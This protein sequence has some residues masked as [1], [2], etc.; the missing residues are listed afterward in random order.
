MLLP[1]RVCNKGAKRWA[2]LIAGMVQR[3]CELNRPAYQPARFL[4]WAGLML[5]SPLR[6]WVALGRIDA[7]GR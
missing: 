2:G 4:P 6:C 7:L 5:T 3:V 1:S